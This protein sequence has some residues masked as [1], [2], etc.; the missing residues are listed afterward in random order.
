[1]TKEK[2]KQKAKGLWIPEC[3]L[4]DDRL[5]LLEKIILSTIL[6][7]SGKNDCYASN[8]YIA[9]KCQCTAETVSRT[10][11]KG[12]KLEYISITADE[13]NERVIKSLLRADTSPLDPAVNPPLRE[14]TRPLDPPVNDPLR[15]ESTD[16][17]SFHLLYN[18]TDYNTV[19]SSSCVTN[20]HD[21]LYQE[22]KYLEKNTSLPLRSTPTVEE[23]RTFCR[24]ENL[25]IDPEKFVDYYA[26]RGWT[27][28]KSKMHSWQATARNWHRKEL[29]KPGFRRYQNPGREDAFD[30]VWNTL[31][32]RS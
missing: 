1:M 27:L 13:K 11:S 29:Q 32:T 3:I 5:S 14:E 17:T 31:L 8:K 15:E 6:T 10:I 7:L 25:A 9:D 18:N 19:H 4:Y 2:G 26:A 23:V 16:S 30:D 22:K 21:G 12:K 24:V 20:H 28:G